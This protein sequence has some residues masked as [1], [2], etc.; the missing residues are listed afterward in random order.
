M[1]VFT[2]RT[3]TGKVAGWSAIDDMIISEHNK[4]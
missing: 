4:K 2:K 1:A 3:N